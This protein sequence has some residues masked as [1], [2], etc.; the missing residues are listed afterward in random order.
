MRYPFIFAVAALLAPSAALAQARPPTIDA[1]VNADTIGLDETLRLTVTVDH[2]ATQPYQGYT[3]PDPKD[4]DIVSQGETDSTQWTI[5]NGVQSSRTIEQHTYLLRPKHKGPCTIPPASVRFDGKEL[6]SRAIVV[7]VVPAGKGP[8]QQQPQSPFAGLPGFPSLGGSLFGE[9]QGPS[10]MTGNE[11][12]YIEARADRAQA[13]VGDQVIVSWYLYSRAD[14]RL[15]RTI[16]EPKTDD[17]WSEELYAPPGKLSW[18]RQTVKGQPYEVALLL[19]KALF[20]LHAG[21]LVV[22]PLQAE[23]TTLQTAFY[24]GAS[25]VRGSK[26]ITIDVLPL[27]KAGQPAG[28]ET[29][30]VGQ[31]QLAGALDKQR[32]KAGEAVTYTLTVRGRGNLRNVKLPVLDAVEGFKVYEPAVKQDLVRGDGGVEGSKSWSYLMLPRKGGALAIPEV[33]LAYF[34][35]VEK[36]YR[37]ATA[38]SVTVNVEGDPEKIGAGSKDA[39]KENVLGPRILPLRITHHVATQIGERVLR[40]R[41]F[42]IWLGAPPSLLLLFVLGGAVR[43]RLSRETERS[44]RRRARAAARRRMRACEMHIKGQRPSAFFGECARSLYEHL[45]YRLGMKCESYTNEELRRLL[46][47]RGFEQ[48]LAGAIA[49]ELENCDFARFAP[50]AS[51]PGEMRAAIRR[52]RHLLS[53]IE[54]ARLAGDEQRKE[55]A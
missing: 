9:P 50:S 55:A 52:V 28:F 33:T 53:M 36:R 39:A 1:A 30:N 13:Y 26:A 49:S 2:D 4:L 14:I 34:D 3:R 18:E 51:G 37:E 5:V 11:D 24:A 22:T 40:G 25:A 41:I 45:E 27:P 47:D 23:A 44:K 42:W 10:G 43:E 12:I 8:Q 6:K 16:A 54:K 31:F 20:P 38:P 35:P 19:R 29:P 15:Y 46:A 17:F 48:E 32:V 7:R 21:K